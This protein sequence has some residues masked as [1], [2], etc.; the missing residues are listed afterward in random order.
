MEFVKWKVTNWK[1]PEL[2]FM[3]FNKNTLLKLP[4][5]YRGNVVI[6]VNIKKKTIRAFKPKEKDALDDIEKEIV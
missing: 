3:E 2:F 1:D 4:F 5:S 6:Q